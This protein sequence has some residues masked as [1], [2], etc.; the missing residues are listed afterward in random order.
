MLNYRNGLDDM[1]SYDGVE[2]NYRVKVNANESTA[3]SFTSIG[4]WRASKS[5]AEVSA[6]TNKEISDKERYFIQLVI[7]I[8]QKS[9]KDTLSY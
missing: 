9:P 5:C 7:I 8:F 4:A 6:Q 1:P 2:K 3:F